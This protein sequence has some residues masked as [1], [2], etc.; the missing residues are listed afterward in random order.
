MCQVIRTTRLLL[1][2]L[3]LSGSGH[4]CISQASLKLYIHLQSLHYIAI[5]CVLFKCI[6]VFSFEALKKLYQS[7]V[8]LEKCVEIYVTVSLGVPPL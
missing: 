8:F 7:L 1:R 5:L 6:I 3:P 4:L 2:L